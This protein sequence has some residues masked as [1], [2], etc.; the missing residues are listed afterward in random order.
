MTNGT[1]SHNFITKNDKTKNAKNFMTDVERKLKL[2]YKLHENDVGWSRD[3]SRDDNKTVNINN[4]LDNVENIS[5]MS[6]TSPEIYQPQAVIDQ[7]TQSFQQS[8]GQLKKGERVDAL[9]RFS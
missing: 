9:K 8:P 4:M 7:I 6:L 1:D 3:S 5:K 2:S